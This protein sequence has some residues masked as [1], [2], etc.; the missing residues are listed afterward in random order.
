MKTQDQGIPN[1]I[2]IKIHSYKTLI[3][4]I[5]I[6]FAGS[7]PV[8]AENKNSTQIYIAKCTLLFA[9]AM[10]TGAQINQ[11]GVVKFWSLQYGRGYITYAALRMKN[12]NIHPELINKEMAIIAKEYSPPIPDIKNSTKQLQTCQIKVGELFNELEFSNFKFDK[13]SKDTLMDL[14]TSIANIVRKDLG[15]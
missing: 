1:L 6:F 15:F 10:N 3:I 9:S 14:S 5:A 12:N 7:L 13:N 2:L 4:A 11:P 8:N